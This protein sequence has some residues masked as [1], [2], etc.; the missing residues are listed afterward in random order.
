M[1]STR[2]E[3]RYGWIGD[4]HAEVI[5]AVHGAIVEGILIPEKDRHVRILEYPDYAFAAAPH[6]GPNYTLVE[7]TM[8]SGRSDDAKRRL[9]SAIARALEPFGVPPA[10]VTV[11]VKD[12][13]RGNWGFGGRS[14]M[15]LDL[16]FKI[17]V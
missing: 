10:D 12:V 3:T 17:E 5:A 11:I 14:A 16:K 15:D 8:F 4:R 9:Y 2:L 7:V 1:P 13:P 6:N